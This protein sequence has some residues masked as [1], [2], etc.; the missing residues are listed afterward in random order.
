MSLNFDEFNSVVEVFEKQS[1]DDPINLYKVQ[2][3]AFESSLISKQD[4]LATGIDG[5]RTVEATV[6]MLESAKIKAQVK[7]K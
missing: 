5:L 7:L 1:K 4:P 3:E 6:A 2:V